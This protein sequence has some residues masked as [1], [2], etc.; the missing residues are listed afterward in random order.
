MKPILLPL[1]L[2]LLPA[3]AHG[4][5]LSGSVDTAPGHTTSGTAV[6]LTA[7]GTTNWAIWDFQSGADAATT[8]A[9]SNTLGTPVA[10][11]TAGYI[12]GLT[13]ISPEGG[14]GNL[15][16]SG[17]LG[18][19]FF[20]YSN[21]ADPGSLSPPLKIGTAFSSTLDLEG[22]GMGFTVTG[23]PSQLYRVSI[24]AV[25]FN[26]QGTLTA[27]LNGATS[28]P[29]VTQ[30]FINAKAPVLFTIEFQ[31]DSA[32]DLLH[33]SYILTTDTPNGSGTTGKN[34]HVAIQAV[35]VEAI[36]EPSAALALLGAFGLAGI[37]RRRA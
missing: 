34:S 25:G 26:G 8:R 22:T 2:A 5:V 16:G 37:R 20:T 3:A 14:T 11:G 30:T 10:P 4:V 18:A 15:Q 35:T 24:W 36:P 28:L 33:L 27:S 23:D 1:S 17:T 6:D 32:T 19:T 9:P 12:S 13:G 29:L 31:P 7:S 21:G